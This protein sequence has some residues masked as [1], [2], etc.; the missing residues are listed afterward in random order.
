MKRLYKFSNRLYVTLIWKYRDYERESAPVPIR[1]DNDLK[2]YF[3]AK[4]T[5]ERS[6]VMKTSTFHEN[7]QSNPVIAKC[8]FLCYSLRFIDSLIND[9]S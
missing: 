9:E 2:K 1:S 3:C 8:V 5:V 4:Y 7:P 6:V